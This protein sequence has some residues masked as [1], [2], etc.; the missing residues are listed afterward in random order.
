MTINDNDLNTLFRFN[1]LLN[2]NC[3]EAKI[4]GV[5]LGRIAQPTF[6]RH[7]KYERDIITKIFNN[8]RTFSI[9]DQS[10]A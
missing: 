3:M 4:F 2:K 10:P 6:A 8:E 5:V 9:S 7:I 1:E